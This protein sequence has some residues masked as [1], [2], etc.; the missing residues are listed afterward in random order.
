MLALVIQKGDVAVRSDLGRTFINT[1]GNNTAM[2]DWQ[3]LATPADGISSINGFTGTVV[4]TTTHINEGMNLYYT[5]A[6]VIANSDVAANTAN[7]HNHANKVILDATTASFTTELSNDI[8]INSA[9]VGITSQQAADI[10]SNNTHRAV[11]AGNP[12]QVTKAEVGLSVVP[13][14]DFTISVTANNAHRLTTSGN[15]HQVTKAEV[16]LSNVPNTDFTIQATNADTHIATVSGNPHAVTKAEVGLGVVPNHDFTAE[17]N[18]NT[19]K[20]GITPQQTADIVSNNAHRVTVAG[21]PHAVTKAE[22]G[23]GIV[24]NHDFTAEVNANTA[25]QHTHANKPVLDASTAAFTTEQADAIIASTA[26]RNDVTTNPHAITPI[27][28]GAETPAGAQT[29]ATI[30]KNDAIDYADLFFRKSYDPAL[31]DAPFRNS[32]ALNQGVGI[33]R[34]VR[35]T[36]A[37]FIDRYGVKRNRIA[38]EPRFNKSGLIQEGPSTNYFVGS[39]DVSVCAFSNCSVELNKLWDAAFEATVDIV[40][41]SIDGQPW[42][43]SKVISALYLEKDK[44][45]TFSVR[46]KSNDGV[47][48]HLRIK[49]SSGTIVG[50]IGSKEIALTDKLA[51]YELTVKVETNT[52]GHPIVMFEP[53]TTTAG[54]SFAVVD[55]QVEELNFASSVINTTVLTGPVTRAGETVG[56]PHVENFPVGLVDKTVLIDVEVVGTT[57]EEHLCFTAGDMRLYVGNGVPNNRMTRVAMSAESTTPWIEK[58]GKFRFGAT[59][60]ATTKELCMYHDGVKVATKTAVTTAD[61]PL[62]NLESINNFFSEIYPDLESGTGTTISQIPLDVL[63]SEIL[64]GS[65]NPYISVSNIRLFDQCLGEQQMLLM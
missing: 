13:N 8:G 3:E 40:T 4:L 9:K 26:H 55:F 22:V 15:P 16:G 34:F 54:S 38:T 59:F 29:K 45:I 44:Y 63:D 7:R 11:V 27:M 64:L 10:I 12:H 52:I 49:D 30:A 51:R 58:I 50:D 24:P 19:A 46:L 23:L 18:A 20:V 43:I 60:N 1:N 53:S 57:D 62:L 21:N 39:T 42:N 33:V 2:S 36:E 48:G 28:I 6:R 47:V 31:F 17:V 61:S 25:A 5:E 37:S 35:P 65:G 32:L 56:I 14:T 41:I